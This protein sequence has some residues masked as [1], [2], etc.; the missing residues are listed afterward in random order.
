M[1]GFYNTYILFT[2]RFG[3]VDLD[4][5][6]AVVERGQCEKV[7]VFSKI[8]PHKNLS[9]KLESAVYLDIRQS[10]TPKKA[11]KQ[12]RKDLDEDGT[13]KTSVVFPLE[14]IA[15]RSLFHDVC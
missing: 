11:A 6:Q 15:D 5:I 10:E 8:P 7:V 12:F 3:F 1:P 4:F 2:D 9:K 13:G 14:V